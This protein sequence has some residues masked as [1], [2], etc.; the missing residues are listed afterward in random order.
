MMFFFLLGSFAGGE[1]GECKWVGRWGLGETKE[2][3]L[4]SGCCYFVESLYSSFSIFFVL[5]SW[6]WN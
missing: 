3:E 2:R 5:I 1:N 4:N 6:M